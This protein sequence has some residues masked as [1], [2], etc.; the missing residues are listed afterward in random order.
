MTVTRGGT[1]VE[2]AIMV[3]HWVGREEFRK[4]YVEPTNNETYW[5]QRRR[6]L[7]YR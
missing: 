4:G 7:V 6:S 5:D 3:E 1:G 2:G